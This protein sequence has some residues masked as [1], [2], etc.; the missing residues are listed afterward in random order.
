MT[1]CEGCP[2]RL[3][4]SLWHVELHLKV[5]IYL[6]DVRMWTEW[7]QTKQHFVLK[8]LNHTGQ[9][10]TR[11]LKN[12]NNSEAPSWVKA[13]KK[14]ILL[15]SKRW[16]WMVKVWVTAARQSCLQT[17]LTHSVKNF[18]VKLEE[19]WLSTSRTPGNHF[20][21]S[22]KLFPKC[23]LIRLAAWGSQWCG[24]GVAA[25]PQR[26]LRPQVVTEQLLSLR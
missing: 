17:D 15:P 25:M 18:A 1:V 10:S 3:S 8:M 14:K 19:S 20:Q 5:E 13:K 12:K 9:S 24:R 22:I 21:I 16:K 2:L 6:R 7:F 23:I 4:K 26:S 11:W